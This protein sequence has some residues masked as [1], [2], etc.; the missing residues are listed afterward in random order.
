MRP[1]RFALRVT[2]ALALAACSQRPPPIV[3]DATSD[4]TLQPDATGETGPSLDAPADGR[5]DTLDAGRD[6]AR[7]DGAVTPED[8]PVELDA[9][10]PDVAIVDGGPCTAVRG[11]SA[12]GAETRVLSRPVYVT[13]ESRG[14]AATAAVL[15]EGAENVWLHRLTADGALTISGNVTEV[16]AGHQ[17]RGGALAP[18]G[19]LYVV[20]YSSD[21]DGNPEIYLR[22]VQSNA[23]P[24]V[25]ARLRIT[26]DAA[27]SETP[28]VVPRRG[29]MLVAWRSV[30]SG[31]ARLLVASVDAALTTAS[32]PVDVG[33]AGTDVTTFRLV[34][35]L[36]PEMYGIVWLDAR[37]GEIRAQAL[38][39]TGAATGA[40]QTLARGAD[41]GDH[42][43]AVARNQDAVVV[44]TQ[45]RSAPTLRVRRIALAPGGLGDLGPVELTGIPA[46]VAQP[47]IALD[48]EGYA[49][50]YRTGPSSGV[51]LALA[52]LGA[53][54]SLRDSSLVAGAAP[55][56]AVG[57]AARDDG[58]YGLAWADD[59]TTGTVARMIVVQ[60]P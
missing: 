58:R 53:D 2:F 12:F 31:S 21:E 37:A 28:Q 15:R 5:G 40:V 54:L 38:T 9:P 59:F 11:A 4:V 43:D 6:E 51:R 50:G 7:T 8:V 30:E 36:D 26:R 10:V 22:R 48:G 23:R 41:L 18:E 55:G 47:G 44:W 16:P 34:T 13:A 17:V 56:G 49:L 42:L 27:T 35:S 24:L 46:P 33:G 32:T 60:C 57:I 39:A 14:F 52:R 29:G 20:A 19:E 45:P 25:G 1:L 3:E